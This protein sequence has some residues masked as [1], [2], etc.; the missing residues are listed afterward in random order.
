MF[1]FIF[2]FSPS[3]IYVFHN[4]RMKF[5]TLKYKISSTYPMCYNKK[6]KIIFL[7]NYSYDC[8]FPHVVL[9]TI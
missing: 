1:G 3:K 8:I 6:I 9:D 2:H 4:I 7:L 5:W